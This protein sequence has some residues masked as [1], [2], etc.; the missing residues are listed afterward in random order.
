MPT[1]A[2][3]RSVPLLLMLTALQVVSSQ[4]RSGPPPIIDMHMH[5]LG[6][7]DQGPPP[8]FVCPVSAELM[9]PQHQDKVELGELMSCAHP[10]GSTMTDDAIRTKTLAIMEKYNVTGVTSGSMARVRQ[11]KAA[12]PRRI[13]PAVTGGSIDSIRAWG[14]SHQI[15]VIGELGLQYAGIA[16]NSPIVAQYLA[17]GEE[18]D[19][20]V[21]LHVGPGP[22]GAVYVAA[23]KYR[24]AA[25]DPLLL[26]EALIAHPR[27]RVDV[28]HAGW[29]MIDNMIALMWAHPQV[30][31]DV[32]VLSWAVPRAEYYSYLK[33]LIDAGFG[34]RVMFGS[35][36]MVWPEA[37]EI[38]IQGIQQAPFLTAQQKR[39]IL[40]NNAARFLRLKAVP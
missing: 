17:L 29:P 7:S 25:S 40:Y 18:L 30:Y 34:K 13:V 36:Q 3:P 1:Y 12:A 33:R 28:M 23:P 19:L 37:L 32:G 24:M 38:A 10:L 14:K 11:W 6:A 16:P 27:A 35:D 31:V 22:P 39:D 15:E 4:A 21:A 20:P 8:V 26:E 2:V 9:P 5:A